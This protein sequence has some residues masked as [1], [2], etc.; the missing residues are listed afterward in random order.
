[1]GHD[2]AF[3]PFEGRPLAEIAR[4]ALLEAGAVEVL[5]IG[6]DETRL[7]ALGFTAIPDDV[8]GQGPLGG[9]LTALR[10][11]TEDWVVVLATDLPRASA[12]T[13]RELL[14]HTGD[15]SD[16]VV[17]LLAGRPQ[18]AHAVWRRDCRQLLE[19]LFAAGERRLRQA[20]HHVRT[21]LVPVT[22]PMSLR[23]VDTPGDLQ[24][25]RILPSRAPDSVANSPADPAGAGSG[26]SQWGM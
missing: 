8:T 22:D 10:A 5:S 24:S 14:A 20:L 13:V 25:L 19:P 6:G 12:G 11:A 18:P 7:A 16:A 23:D 21:S 3:A 2:K 15:G 26:S 4:C 17:P 9:L 1:M